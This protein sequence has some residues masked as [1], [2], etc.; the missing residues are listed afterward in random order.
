MTPWP[1]HVD[2]QI[3]GIQYKEKLPSIPEQCPCEMKAVREG[4]WRRL[5]SAANRKSHFFDQISK[6]P[7][8]HVIPDKP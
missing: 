6:T 7:G 2:R 8:V 1:E 5:P 3:F 4:V